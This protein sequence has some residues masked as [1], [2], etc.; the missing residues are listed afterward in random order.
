MLYALTPVRPYACTHLS[1]YAFMHLACRY[2]NRDREGVATKPNRLV[3]VQEG[4]RQR[5]GFGRG[6]GVVSGA[7][8]AEEAVVGK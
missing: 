3:L 2:Q 7:G 6:F 1:L 8:V 4:Q 5:P